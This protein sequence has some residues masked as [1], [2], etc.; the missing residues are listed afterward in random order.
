MI[1]RLLVT[2]SED[3]ISLESARLPWAIVGPSLSAQE[4]S[5]PFEEITLKEA[6]DR[7]ERQLLQDAVKRFHTTYQIAE[8]LQISQPSVSRKLKKYGLALSK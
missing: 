5:S 6:F 4:V 3:I 7:V 1:E 2:S 8:A